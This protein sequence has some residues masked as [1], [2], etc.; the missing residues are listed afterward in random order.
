MVTKCVC[1]EKTFA[2]LKTIAGQVGATTV[3]ALQ[4]HVEFGHNCQLCHP[5]IRRMLLTGETVFDVIKL[6]DQPS[7]RE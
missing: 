4:R 2:E 5:Y 1:Y 3:E 7:D 6:P